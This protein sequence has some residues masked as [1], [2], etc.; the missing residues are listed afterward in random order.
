MK[1]PVDVAFV[2]NYLKIS[3]VTARAV[4]QDMALNGKIR[5]IKTTNGLQYYGLMEEE[6]Q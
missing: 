1:M 5:V 3:W 6:I 2:A 4:L